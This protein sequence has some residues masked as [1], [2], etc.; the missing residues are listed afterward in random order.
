M[1]A[2]KANMYVN[3]LLFTAVAGIMSIMLLLLLI[4]GSGVAGQYAVV[5]VTVEVGLILCIVMSI[6]RIMWFE[7]R[8]EKQQRNSVD[9]LLAVKTCP[10][11]WTMQNTDKGTV[12]KNTYKVGGVTFREMTGKTNIVN[13]N[14][15]TSPKHEINLKDLDN[16][17]LG[18]VCKQIKNQQS[19]WTDYRTV[20]DSYNIDTTH[21]NALLGR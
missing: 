21:P 9:N 17:K 3:T 7:R 20:C 1:A 18:E 16:K 19:P 5:I 13:S 15:P 6:V 4:Y 14:D 10:D 12:C 8:V 2:T 11:Y